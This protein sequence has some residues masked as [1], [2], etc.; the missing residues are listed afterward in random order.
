MWMTVLHSHWPWSLTPS[1]LDEHA[2]PQPREDTSLFC[3]SGTLHILSYKKLSVNLR[4]HTLPWPT[5]CMLVILESV[6]ICSRVV[7]VEGLLFYLPC[8]QVDVSI[9][10]LPWRFCR[11]LH[12]VLLSSPLEI[13]GSF[14]A[15]AS[16]SQVL[17]LSLWPGTGFG[18]EEL[19]VNV[20]KLRNGYVNSI[21]IYTNKDSYF[22]HSVLGS[23]H[24]RA[25]LW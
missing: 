4:P 20:S 3:I 9:F 1:V 19:S 23:E 14:G 25:R 12:L 15:K 7:G 8:L 11:P 24:R 22:F 6:C 17:S 18:S 16:S 2:R 10:A 5:N 13:L 21:H